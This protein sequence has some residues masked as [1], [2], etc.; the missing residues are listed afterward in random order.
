MNQLFKPLN[1]KIDI[2]INRKDIDGT[3]QVV[4][5]QKTNVDSYL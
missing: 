2:D 5:K 3:H 4:L 1:Q